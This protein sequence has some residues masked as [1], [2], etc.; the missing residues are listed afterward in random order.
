MAS[1][2]TATGRPRRAPRR[3]ATSSSV[4]VGTFGDDRSTPSIVISPGTPM[5]IGI[6]RA[7]VSTS[8]AT[9]PASTSISASPSYGVRSRVSATSVPPRLDDDT[10]ALRAADVD[11]EQAAGL[12][13]DRVQDSARTLSSRT[14]LRMRTSARRLTKPGSGAASSMARS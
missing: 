6:D 3:P 13:G 1:L 14:E 11:P 8:S 9:I 2:D 10:E 5:P 4:T 7:D 12:V